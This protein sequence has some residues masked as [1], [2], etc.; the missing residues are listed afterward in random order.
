[1][2]GSESVEKLEDGIVRSAEQV[3]AP[4]A[5]GLVLVVEDDRT[6]SLLAGKLLEAI[7]YETE[8][9]VNGRQATEAFVP[10]KFAAILMDMQMP[11]MDGIEATKK[12]REHESGMRVPII[13]LTANVMP[14]DL[15]RCLMVGMDDF[16]SKPFNK[17]D[18]ARKLAQLIKK[19]EADE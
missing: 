17:S 9:A 19:P 11:V 15:E 7:G 4:P 2:A 5:G 10:G 16:L 12:I 18:L 14:G 3:S 13:A 8:F 1:M 6:S